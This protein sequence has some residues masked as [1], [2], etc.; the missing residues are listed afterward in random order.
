MTLAAI[1]QTLFAR[2][3]T[4]RVSG[5][6]PTYSLATPF[7]MVDRYVGPIEE[8]GI[9]EACA[10]YP[11]CLLRADGDGATR[12][13]NVVSGDSEDR[14]AETWSV[15]I[16]V[17]D[18]RAIVDGVVGVAGAPGILLLIDVVIGA[19]NGLYFADSYRQRRIRYTGWRYELAKRGNLYVVA[20]GFEAL[21]VAPTTD[22][23]DAPNGPDSPPL[24]E[25]AGEVNLEGTSDPAPN[26]VNQFV[27][28]Y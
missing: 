27:V 19:L 21:R 26:P 8:E 24:T 5:S 17:E 12:V 6:P 1:D 20:V 13:V 4:L 18:P 7:A 25:I 9:R 23:P 2:L 28:P 10:L 3:E 15:L 14:V 16:A 22:E 11:A